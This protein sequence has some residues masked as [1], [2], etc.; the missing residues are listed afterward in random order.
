MT[1]GLI[2]TALSL[3]FRHGV[4]WD[5]IAAIADLSTTA[6]ERRRGFVLSFMYALG[7]AVVVFALGVAAIVFG[8]SLPE[9]FDDWLG[10]FVGATLI[11][12][13]VW[14]LVDLARNGREFRLRSRFM[15]VLDGAFAGVRRV[16]LSGGRRQIEVEHDH[17]H[18]HAQDHHHGAAAGT[19]AAVANE[20]DGR[21]LHGHADDLGAGSGHR[22]A[23]PHTHRV[24]L[25]QD[26]RSGASVKTAAGIGVVHGIGFESPTQIAIF[27]ASTSVVGTTGGLVLLAAWMLGLIIANSVL[28]VLAGFGLLN[29]DKNFAIYATL[30]VVVAAVSVVMGLLLVTGA[31]VLP[32]LLVE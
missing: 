14:I 13:G 32:A 5:H 30:A 19:G 7:H 1:A 12:L 27:V 6:G 31:D 17:P 3:G 18:G 22:H 9:S 8:A 26:G 23:H 4:D 24:S 2:L 11:L 28:A 29:A 15:L 21:E 20:T 16:R 25:P 10:K